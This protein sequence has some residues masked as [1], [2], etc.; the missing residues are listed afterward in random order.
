MRGVRT[1]EYWPG[2]PSV[3][4]CSR[5]VE[6]KVQTPAD[7]VESYSQQSNPD[8]DPHPAGSVIHWSPGSESESLNF[9]SG[10]LLFYR[11]EIKNVQ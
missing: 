4:K 7:V 11:R 6:Y 8:P 3:I 2:S 5:M 9:G 1:L 10:S